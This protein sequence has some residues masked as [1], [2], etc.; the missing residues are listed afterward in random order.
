MPRHVPRCAGFH[1]VP[2][3]RDHAVRRQHVVRVGR[4]SPGTTRSCSTWAPGC[5]TSAPRSRRTARS[6]ARASSP[7]S[8]GTTRRVCRSS[9]RCCSEGAE[10]DVY[11]PDAGR[12]P[13]GRRGL[14]RDDPPAAVPDRPRHVPGDVP[15]PRRRRRRLHGRRREGDVAAR[16][17]RRRDAR[18][19]H[20]VERPQRRLPQRPPA[21][22]RRR[23]PRDR[24]RARARPRRRPADPRLAVHAGGVPAKYNWGH[25]TVDYAVWLAQSRADGAVPPRP[26]RR[27]AR[28]DARWPADG[29]R[30]RPRAT[31]SS[32]TPWPATCCD[33]C[34]HVGRQLA[35]AAGAQRSRPGD[36]ELGRRRRVAWALPCVTARGRRARRVR[37]RCSATVRTSHVARTSRSCRCG[38][39]SAVV[40]D[41]EAERA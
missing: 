20:R 28:R 1:P 15:L 37:A 34:A 16:P 6:A 39:R 2:R 5:A 8:T 18:L 40:D 21:A 30:C 35:G 41:G 14:R 31:S 9:R 32:T 33:A 4:R 11:A 13:H 26:T 12:R 23:V 38:R 25:C 7:T 3:R 24:R 36:C 10:L 19:P 17:A 29:S 27:R 22:V